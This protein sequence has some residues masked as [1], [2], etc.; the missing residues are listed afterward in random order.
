M[1]RVTVVR[2]GPS[3]EYEISLKSGR[4][5]VQALKDT[6]YL[7]R[8][9]LITKAGE[10]LDGGVEKTAETI[11]GATDVAFLATHGTFGE[12]GSLQKLLHHHRVP[13]TGSGVLASA[14]AFNKIEA[15]VRVKDQL[16]TPKHHVL[17]GESLWS[18][19]EVLDR[20]YLDESIEYLLKP[21]SGGSSHDTY[22]I[23]NRDILET[24]LEILLPKHGR[25]LLE[26]F[27]TGKEVTV[28]VLENFRGEAFYALPPVEV[29]PP[30]GQGFFTTSAKYSGKSTYHVPARL[31]YEEKQQVADA[32]IAAHQLLGCRQYSRSDFIISNGKIHYLETNTLPGMTAESLLPKAA[33]IVGIEF[34]DLVEHLIETA[35][36]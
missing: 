25:V 30:H 27:V 2:G 22:R 32:A 9:V 33:S 26:E 20:V 7:V 10:W 17:R 36:V 34:R 24:A 16:I 5:I 3:E 21:V 14:L 12:D 19:A 29:V 4:A 11:L 6:D 31:T 8:D 13:H 28:G 35:S 23:A 18:V 15:K 1:K